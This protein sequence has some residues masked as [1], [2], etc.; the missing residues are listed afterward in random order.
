ME[1]D[2]CKEVFNLIQVNNNFEIM[3]MM[4]ANSVAKR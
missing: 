2:I 3:Y 4:H 1:T